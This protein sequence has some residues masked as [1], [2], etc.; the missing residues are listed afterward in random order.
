MNMISQVLAGIHHLHAK[1]IVH[2]D[3][4]PSNILV[5]KSQKPKFVIID[6]NIANVYKQGGLHKRFRRNLNASIVGTRPFASLFALL[7]CLPFCRD[8]IESF[9]LVCLYLKGPRDDP[10]FT[11]PEISLS[12]LREMRIAMQSKYQCIK[13]LRS[14]CFFEPLDYDLIYEMMVSEFHE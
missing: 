2:C 9:F 5:T 3:I 1:G 12:N 7:R 6:L 4:K 8:D 10:I 11:D 13:Y 14:I